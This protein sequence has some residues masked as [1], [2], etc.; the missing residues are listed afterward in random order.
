[1]APLPLIKVGAVLFKE[2]AKPIAA[3][4]K[5]QAQNHER[6]R[7]V[8]MRV[9][10]VWEG[11]AQR[12][13]VWTRGGK[14]KELKPITDAHA[15]SAGADFVSQAFLLATALAGGLVGDAAMVGAVRHA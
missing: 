11:V 1:M 9:G 12:L 5:H 10:R 2:L 15:M 7:L 14:S 3:R 8:T 4:I 6:F 13:E